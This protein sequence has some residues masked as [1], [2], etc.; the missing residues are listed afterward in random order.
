MSELSALVICSSGAVSGCSLHFVKLILCC[1]MFISI[2]LELAFKTEF[3][4]MSSIT[5]EENVCV[6]L[7]KHILIWVEEQTYWIASR[8]LML[9]FEL[10]L[11]SP[12][13]Y[14]MVYWYIYV[15]LIKLAEK[16]HLKMVMS[17]DTGKRKG[18]KKRDS[19]KDVARDYQIPPAVLFLQCHISLAEGLT[20]L[21]AAL[22]N[23]NRVFQSLGP[24]N[25]E[26]EIFIQ[27]FELLQQACIPD[28]ISYLSFKDTTAYAQFSTLVMYNYFKDALRLAKELRSSFSNDP[29]R[30]AELRKIEQVAEHNGIALNVICRVGALDP[31]L[32]VS[33]EFNHHP[34]F[35]TAVVRR[36]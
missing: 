4:E 32:K 33:F 18:K 5:N 3:G 30:M 29:D 11:Y 6:K 15:V 28:H 25:T 20:M 23:E 2:Q 13:E 36:S 1:F 21:L 19:P 10:E 34:Y 14:C 35:A 7:S 17:N 26:H 16:H 8:F 22:R 31:S 27:H 24:F 9:G 12:S